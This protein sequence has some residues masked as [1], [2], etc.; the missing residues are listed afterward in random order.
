MF[1]LK[2]LQFKEGGQ[3]FLL[4]FQIIGAKCLTASISR[5]LVICGL[6]FIFFSPEQKK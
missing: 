3:G 2:K 4:V 1:V 6:Y 5:M